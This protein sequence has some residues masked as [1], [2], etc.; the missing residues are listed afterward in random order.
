M[1]YVCKI[2]IPN[3]TQWG[4]V[5]QAE[6]VLPAQIRAIKSF[7]ANAIPSEQSSLKRL[8]IDGETEPRDILST[9]IG[10]ISATVNNTVVIADNTPLCV[11]NELSKGS[12]NTLKITQPKPLTIDQGA[13]FRLLI[14]EKNIC[15]FSS[16]E[17]QTNGYVAKF[18]IEY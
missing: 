15:P 7:L 13:P 1:I 16:G 3:R 2:E 8:M 10:T 9:Q 17:K 14:E 11:T 18:Y 5:Y 12:F 6:F 4:D